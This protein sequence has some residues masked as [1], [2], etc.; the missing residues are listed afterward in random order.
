M[1]YLTPEPS[2]I[3]R[4]LI[5]ATDPLSKLLIDYF[6]PQNIIVSSITPQDFLYPSKLDS[7]LNSHDVINYLIIT[8]PAAFSNPHEI[9]SSAFIDQILTLNLEFAKIIYLIPQFSSL[10]RSL[11]HN[12]SINP[13]NKFLNQYQHHQETD[14]AIL[15]S[16]SKLNI[17]P[18]P[19]FI[20]D[21]YFSQPTSPL[22]SIIDFHLQLLP[23]KML[24]YPDSSQEIFSP[25]YFPETLPSIAKILFTQPSK[26]SYLLKSSTPISISH[27]F[28]PIFEKMPQLKK[29]N[30]KTTSSTSLELLTD[31]NYQVISLP[32][33]SNPSPNLSAYFANLYLPPTNHQHIPSKPPKIA[34]NTLKKR[35][36]SQMKTSST[37]FPSPVINSTLKI[38]SPLYKRLTHLS[39]ISLLL[40]LIIYISLLVIPV[41][42]LTTSSRYQKSLNFETLTI[43]DITTQNLF[44]NRNHHL[45]LQGMRHLSPLLS[46]IT[47]QLFSGLENYIQLTHNSGQLQLALIEAQFHID[48]ALTKIISLEEGSP[49]S[50]LDQASLSLDRVYL[51]ASSLATKT[52]NSNPLTQ[53]LPVSLDLTSLKELKEKSI[54]SKR[55]IQTISS[56][57]PLNQKVTY[58]ILLQNNLELRPAG[59]FISAV[60]LLTFD[61]SKLINLEVKDVYTVDSQLRGKVEPPLDIKTFLGES[62][63][64]LRDSNWDPDFPTTAQTASWFIDK[65]L[66]RSLSGVISLDAYALLDL[67]KSL[68]QPI[69]VNGNQIDSTN[70]IE[71]LQYHQE[72]DFSENSYKNELLSQTFYQ[73]IEQLKKSDRGVRQQFLTNLSLAFKQRHAAIF[74]NSPMAQ[75]IFNDIA[76]DAAIIDPSCPA[77]INN[78]NCITDYF[79]LVEANVG[80]NKANYYLNKTSRHTINITPSRIHHTLEFSQSNN[81]DTANWPGGLYKAHYRLYLPRGIILESISLNQKPLSPASYQVNQQHG[82]TVV[83]FYN[84]TPISVTDSFSLSYFLPLNLKDTNSLAYTYLIQKQL[85][86]DSSPLDITINYPPSYTPTFLNHPDANH[87]LQS[88]NYQTQLDQDLYYAVELVR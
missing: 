87:N 16:L 21:L 75:S 74:S 41:I 67:L 23:Q 86:S 51:L 50:D 61:N 11:S 64:Y 7:I 28:Q 37:I 20:Q 70:L 58:L 6:S 49:F 72:I 17:F 88:I 4:M 33:T 57:L 60:A 65:E 26:K 10:P 78:Q 15:T 43:K 36:P 14:R 31:I 42:I 62:N 83:S 56:L 40:T 24:I 39:L 9:N 29:I 34:L 8:S 1:S 19:I 48:R 30:F 59:G 77:I 82:K 81:S 27:L 13:I 22:V 71:T 68:P 63:W 12:P 18:T 69:N 25:L 47:P 53:Q 85:G 2:A 44:L 52:Q 45:A 5:L 66:N 32:S 55:L 38:K 3:I 35:P 54:N 76:Y 73:I 46:Q 80:I 79:M 84:S